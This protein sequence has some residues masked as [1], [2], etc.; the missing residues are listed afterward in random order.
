[1]ATFTSITTASHRYYMRKPK[2]EIRQHIRMLC[3]QLDIDPPEEQIMREE[4]AYQLADR[5]MALHRQFPTEA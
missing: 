4:T 3:T 5:A 2:W 1:M